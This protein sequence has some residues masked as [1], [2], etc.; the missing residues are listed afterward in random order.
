MDCLV[1][2]EAD[3][4]HHAA[5]LALIGHAGERL[6]VDA[7][8]HCSGDIA[9]GR[10]LGEALDDKLP[11]ILLAVGSRLARLESVHDRSESAP[12]RVADAGH[13]PIDAALL[14]FF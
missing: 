8:L 7:V 2:H 1:M 6:R 3:F 9:L 10:M 11:K 5:S 12:G 14:A 13:E 4:S